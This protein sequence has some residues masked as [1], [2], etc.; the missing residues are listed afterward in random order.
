LSQAMETLRLFMVGFAALTPP[1]LVLRKG[2]DI[3]IESGAVENRGSVNWCKEK[4]FA[5]AQPGFP[6]VT[7]DRAC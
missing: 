1:Y 5:T 7:R 2:F 3:E 6:P 4:T